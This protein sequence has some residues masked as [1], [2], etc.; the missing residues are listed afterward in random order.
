MNLKYNKTLVIGIGIFTLSLAL[1]VFI[2]G[3]HLTAA[4]PDAPPGLLRAIEVQEAN[5]PDL[6]ANRDVIGTAVGLDKQGI[7]VIRVFAT[8]TQVRGIPRSIDGVPVAVSITDEFYAVPGPNCD[9]DGDGFLKNSGKCGGDDCNDNNPNINPG[10]DEV[11]GDGI[12]NNCNGSVDEGCLVNPTPTPSPSPTPTPSPTA[13]CKPYERCARPVPIGV[14]TGHPNI[15]AGTISCRVKKGSNVYAMSNNHVYA[16]ENRAS[17]GDN[18]LQPGP[19]DGGINPADA[20]GKLSDFQFISFC[21]SSCPDNTID[22]AIALSST[23]NLGNSTL[24]DGYGTPKSTTVTPQVNMAVMKYGRTTGLTAGK[25]YAINATVNVGYDSG[26]ARFVKQI[27]ITPGKF[28]AGG[29]SGS[30]IVEN[31]GTDD[32]KPVGLLFAGS[33]LY[34]IANPIDPVLSRFGVTIDGQ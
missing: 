10:V 19:Y 8:S 27:V 15:T 5:T 2:G 3:D 29:D 4:P 31:G 24:P 23:A 20:I 14:S 28:S 16:D 32:R 25:V 17:I 30:L 6:M 34:T 13:S 7:P 12:D 22:A 33:S 18:V 21:T 1:L 9:R 26:V 11:C